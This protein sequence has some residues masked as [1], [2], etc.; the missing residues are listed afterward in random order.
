MTTLTFPTL[1]RDPHTWTWRKLS[2]TQTFESPLTRGVQTLALPGARWACAATWENLQP[3]DAAL[4]RA[5]L[6]QLQG[7][8]GRFY[9]GNLAHRQPRGTAAGTPKVVG[10]TQTGKTLATDGWTPGATLLAGD[11][12]GYN[13]GAELRMVV[14]DAT[15]SG[16]GAMS[17]SLDEPIR[18]S[19]VDNDD[20]IIARPT[21]V[22]RLSGD[23]AAWNYSPG[24]FASFS[25][26]A[27]EVFA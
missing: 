12:I 3:A 5:W 15:A 6:A 13:A 7:T 24:G 4:L 26:D 20:I 10:G 8:A 19:P 1:S 14:A 18:V 11:F 22:M 9:L 2:N 21:C 27:V 23:E 16:A 25:L 17:I